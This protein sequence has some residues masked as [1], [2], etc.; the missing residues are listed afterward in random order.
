VELPR[1]SFH[2]VRQSRGG[3]GAARAAGGAAPASAWTGEPRRRRRGRGQ[4][5]RR[6]TGELR[7]RPPRAATAEQVAVP[8]DAV[9]V[10]R[11]ASCLPL[12]RGDGGPQRRRPLL[13][14]PFPPPLSSLSR[15]PQRPLPHDRTHATDSGCREL[16]DG[17]VPFPVCRCSN[18]Y[19]KS[20]LRGAIQYAGA[21]S[22][23]TDS[24]LT[25]SPYIGSGCLVPPPII[26][27]PIRCLPHV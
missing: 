19:C 13:P 12:S 10:A 1:R 27:Y 8:G 6:Q 18:F 15:A 9:A 11:D 21:D 23:T 5:A 24:R 22:L 25:S 2:P 4:P 14:R 20:L 16:L 7:R 17:S 3:R 26:C